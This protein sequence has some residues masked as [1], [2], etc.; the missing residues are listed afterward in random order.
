MTK[1]VWDD[2]V[3]KAPK[4]VEGNREKS[5]EG[6]MTPLKAEEYEKP[7]KEARQ[8]SLKAARETLAAKRERSD[9]TSERGLPRRRHAGLRRRSP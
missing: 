5:E 2:F 9:R 1:E 4:T 8:N 3:Q 6:K 7:I